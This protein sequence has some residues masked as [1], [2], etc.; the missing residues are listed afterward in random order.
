MT[1][2]FRKLKF[3]F[4]TWKVDRKLRRTPEIKHTLKEALDSAKSGSIILLE[5]SVTGGKIKLFK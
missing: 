5:P 1:G 3:K 2:F 4:E